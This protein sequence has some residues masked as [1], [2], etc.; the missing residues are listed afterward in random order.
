MPPTKSDARGRTGL[1]LADRHAPQIFSVG[2]QIEE[3]IV[4]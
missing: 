1:A 4:E 3:T 2:H